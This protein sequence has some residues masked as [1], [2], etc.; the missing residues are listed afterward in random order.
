M[1]ALFPVA[2]EDG[3]G[4]VPKKEFLKSRVELIIELLADP[5]FFVDLTYCERV[6]KVMKLAM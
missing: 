3:D 1:E 5:T 4:M 2:D 6:K